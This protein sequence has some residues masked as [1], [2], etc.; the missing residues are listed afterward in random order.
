MHGGDAMDG[1]EMLRPGEVAERLRLSRSATYQ[2][3]ASGQLPVLRIGR[4]VRVPAS[5]LEAWIAENTSQPASP[6]LLLAPRR[7]G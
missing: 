4:A 7:R 3:I 2:L 5:A 1:P 6:L